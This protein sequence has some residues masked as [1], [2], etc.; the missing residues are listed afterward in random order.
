M[1]AA[2]VDERAH[3]APVGAGDENVADME[4]AALDEDGGDRAAALVE[5]RLDHGAFGGAVRVGVELEHFRLEE[6]RLEQLVEVGALGRGDLDVEHL[7]AHRFDEDLVLQ[8]LACA[9]GSGRRRA[10]R[11]C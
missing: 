3:A 4:R 5:L 7:A 1:L 11:S 6:D 8:E 10:C 9:R 2:I